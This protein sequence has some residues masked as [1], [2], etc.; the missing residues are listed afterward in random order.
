MQFVFKVASES[1]DK[2][3]GRDRIGQVKNI[4]SKNPLYFAFLFPAVVD[5][6][7][8]LIGQDPNYWSDKVV[9]EAS[10]AYYFLVASPWVFVLGSFGWFVGWYLI[11]KKLKAPLNLFLAIL[12]ISGHSWGSTGWIW[13]VAKRNGLYSVGDQFSVITV[14]FLVVI[15]FSLISLFATYCVKLYFSKK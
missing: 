15:Y 6:V 13:N 4:I 10:P 9:R 12:F 2:T 7:L 1:F 5:G 8:T 11:F 14:W 3:W